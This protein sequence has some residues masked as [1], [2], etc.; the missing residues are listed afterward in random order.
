VL[1]CTKKPKKEIKVCQHKEKNGTK[2][3]KNKYKNH[4]DDGTIKLEPSKRRT[5][6]KKS[7]IKDRCVIL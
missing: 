4:Y 3:S 6:G 7:V 5:K 1:R 2:H